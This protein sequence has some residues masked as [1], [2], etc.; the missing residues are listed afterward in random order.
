MVN[1]Y[2]QPRISNISYSQ[3]ATNENLK[4]SAASEAVKRKTV[5]RVKLNITLIEEIRGR[6]LANFLAAASMDDAAPNSS[7]SAMTVGS[8]GSSQ[9]VPILTRQKR[10]AELL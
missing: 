10:R 1:V 9:S 2:K 7:F 4:G 6:R 3:K 8:S 5:E